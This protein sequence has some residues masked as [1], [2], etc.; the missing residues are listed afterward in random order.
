MGEARRSRTRHRGKGG[1]PPG[2]RR[3][4]LDTRA[5]GPPAS[6]EGFPWTLISILVINTPKDPK[7]AAPASRASALARA[8]LPAPPDS[9]TTPSPSPPPCPI[10]TDSGQNCGSDLWP[11]RAGSR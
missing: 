8:P 3:P 2:G 6:T 10:E 11:R 1:G 9:P 4:W 7:N 5:V